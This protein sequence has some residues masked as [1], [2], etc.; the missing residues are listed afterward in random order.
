MSAAK[1]KVMKAKRGLELL[2]SDIKR[3]LLC[4][5][6]LSQL[7]ALVRASAR[8]H[9]Q[10]V[11]N[12]RLILWSCIEQT[13]GSATVD[14]YAVYLS[15]SEEEN[16]KRDIKDFLK[17]YEENTLRRGLLPADVLSL[18]GATSIA[19][20]YFRYISTF[21][22]LYTG[23]KLEDLYKAT[24]AVGRNF[25]GRQQISFTPRHTETMRVTR[26]IYRFQLLCHLVGP[27]FEDHSIWS[28][29][30][31]KDETVQALFDILKPWEVEELYSFYCWA[32]DVYDR[33]L[34]ED[35][36]WELHP[37]NPKFADQ[38]RPSTLDGAFDLSG[39]SK[40]QAYWNSTPVTLLIPW[41]YAYIICRS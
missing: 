6:D 29:Q 18:E 9:E 28:S 20:L 16:G 3:H 31:N 17:S 26:A 2:P 35:M 13:L 14:A 25:H 7:K 12:R 37:D 1:L 23:G 34:N 21:A 33:V 36:T 38:E 22:G 15:D 41:M 8:I 30:G 32:R 11:A 19:S 24:R 4:S 40:F 39:S 10:Y 27:R 5:L